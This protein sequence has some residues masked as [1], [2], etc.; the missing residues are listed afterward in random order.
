MCGLELVQE[1][2]TKQPFP[3]AARVAAQIGDAALDRGLVVYPLQGCV[4]GVEGDMV[5]LTP[6][7]CIT[8]AQV[9]ELLA[10][11]DESIGAV[12]AAL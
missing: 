8:A 11:L 9:D 7:L 3:V 12:E 10:I 2:A 5:K 6:P 4:D 1:R